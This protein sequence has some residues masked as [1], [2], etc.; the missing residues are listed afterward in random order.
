MW[1]I[2]ELTSQ[3]KANE[4]EIQISDH[5]CSSGEAETQFLNKS[6]DTDGKVNMFNTFHPF[7]YRTYSIDMTLFSVITEMEKQQQPHLR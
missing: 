7:S 2:K 1:Y 6:G 5:V 4:K 3:Q